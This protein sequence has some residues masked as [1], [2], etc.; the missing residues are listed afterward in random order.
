MKGPRARA[1]SKFP[2]ATRGRLNKSRYCPTRVSS[3]V[4]AGGDIDAVSME[5]PVGGPGDQT[6]AVTPPEALSYVATCFGRETEAGSSPGA[7]RPDASAAPSGAT[8]EAFLTWFSR[9]AAADRVYH[10]EPPWTQ[11]LPAL[12]L[13]GEFVGWVPSEEEEAEFDSEEEAAEDAAGWDAMAGG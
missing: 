10:R 7:V 5:G 4:A 3:S 12:R 11:Y 9:S 1:A 13:G 8:R 6:P 2:R